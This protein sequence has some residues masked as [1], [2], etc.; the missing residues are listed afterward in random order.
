MNRLVFAVFKTIMIAIIFVFVFDIIFYM[1]RV[2]S[3]NSRMESISTSLKKVVMDNNYLPSEQ[4]NMY[5][6]LLDQMVCDFNN[7]PY[8]TGMTNFYNSTPANNFIA[9][10][11]WNYKS[12]PIGATPT[13]T[14]TRRRHNL[15]GWVNYSTNIVNPQ[16]KTPGDYGDISVVQLRVA[17]FQPMWGW[18]SGGMSSQVAGGYDDGGISS[19]AGA[20]NRWTRNANF[21]TTEFTYTYYVPCLNYKTVTE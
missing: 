19:A 11:H 20:A 17:V 8:S 3:L 16:M 21:R 14:A 7:V 15:G 6:V 13:I 18:T 1:Y 10:I 2:T 5:K 12:N 9:G 4:A